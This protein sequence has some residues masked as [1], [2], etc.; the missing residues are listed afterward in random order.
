[1]HIGLSRGKQIASGRGCRIDEI[2]PQ[3]SYWQ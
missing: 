1:M 2:I 3:D